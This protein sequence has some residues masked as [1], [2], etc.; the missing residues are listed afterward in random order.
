M[1][2]MTVSELR[3]RF[4][5][6]EALLGEGEVIQITKCDRVIARLV[7]VKAAAPGHRPDF[8]ARLQ[9]IYGRKRLKVSGAKLIARERSGN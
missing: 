7:P 6:V 1:T 4:R 5:E 8:L 9:K 2:W 3:C